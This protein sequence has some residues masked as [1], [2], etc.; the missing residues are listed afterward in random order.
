MTKEIERKWIVELTPDVREILKQGGIEIKDYYFN[1]YTRLR[2][3]DGEW[4]I[5][6]KSD[7]TLIRDEYEFKIDKSQINFLP[8]PQLVK[9]R[10]LF[11]YSG[12]T[13]EL[14]VFRDIPALNKKTD[15]CHNLILAEVEFNSP[16][17]EIALPEFFSVEVTQ[18][19]R[20]YGYNLLK[21]LEK[22]QQSGYGD[23]AF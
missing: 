14:N 16:D 20:F 7:G 11:E 4:F 18:N 23:I 12:H 8:T 21:S 6:I 5:T 13:F 1:Q 9:K 19:K 10:V 22:Y 15:K 17:E 3:Y 2:N